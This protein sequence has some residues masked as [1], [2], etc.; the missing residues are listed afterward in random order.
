MGATSVLAA[1]E[2]SNEQLKKAVQLFDQGQYEQSQELLLGLDQGKL[3]DDEKKQRDEYADKVTVAIN[4][5][6]KAQQD[7]DDG[8]SLYDGNKLN[9]AAKKYRAVQTNK[10]AAPAQ[11]QEAERRLALIQEKRRLSESTETAQPAQPGSAAPATQPT[12]TAPEPRAA[13]KA[14]P[15]TTRP[16]MMQM[17]SRD[18][19][20]AAALIQRGQENLRRGEFDAAAKAFTEALRL[21]PNDPD[22]LA[23]RQLLEKYRGAEGQP[24]S[25][26]NRYQAVRSLR[27]QRTQRLYREQEEKARELML[28]HKYDEA[29]QLLQIAGRTLEAGKMDAQPAEE[30]ETMHREL[31][32]LEEYLAKEQTRYQEEQ[33]AD[34]VRTARQENIERE[35]RDREE[36]DRKIQQMMERVVQLKKDRKY[37]EAIAQL[38][39]ILVVEPN[40]QRARDMKDDLE[41]L[42]AQLQAGRG[43]DKLITGTRDILQQASLSRTPATEVMTYSDR[44]PEIKAMRERAAPGLFETAESDRLT[45]DIDQRLKGT[46]I[47]PVEFDARPLKE[48]LDHFKTEGKI[49]IAPNW[50]A[51]EIANVTP[52]TEVTATLGKVKLD[53]A[54]KTI[55][56]NISDPAVS[57]IEFEVFGG[58]VRVSTQEDLDQ[59]ATVTRVYDIADVVMQDNKKPRRR[60]EMGGLMGNMGGQG[61]G[62]S[63]GM[64][65]GMGGGMSGGGMSG[66]GMNSGGSSGGGSDDDDDTDTTEKKKEITDSLI[67][68]MKEQIA[69]GTWETTGV[70]VTSF[71]NKKLLIRHR[72]SIQ[73]QVVQLLKGLSKARRDQVAVEARLL[74]IRKNFLEEIGLDL[75][76]V[77]NQGTAGFDRSG[78]TDATTGAPLLLPRQFGRVG[79]TPNVPAVGSPLPQSALQQPY[80]NVAMVPQA[81]GYGPTWGKSTPIPILNNSLS[82]AQPQSTPVPGSLGGQ[83]QPAL[84]VFGSFLDNIQVDFL[85]RATQADVHSSIVDAPRLVVASGDQSWVSVFESINYVF[86]VYPVGA[87]VFTTGVASQAALAPQVTQ[88]YT[89]RRLIVTATVSESRDYVTLQVSPEWSE[90]VSIDRFPWGPNGEGFI[91]QPRT[92][93]TEFSTTVTV[94]DE[95]TLLLGGLTLSGETEVEAGVPVLSK[96]PVLKRLYS[97]RSL[98]KDEYVAF[99]LIKPHIIV[100]SEQEERAFPGMTSS[101]EAGR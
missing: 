37:P 19:E 8:N 79:F 99:V 46:T 84:Q 68:L 23:G 70:S 90:L 80:S 24:S 77:L 54:L 22:A 69:P 32:Q 14:A 72:P 59:T 85:L 10:Y 75:D 82:L 25:L 28:S 4:Q 30:Y 15:A 1:A 60:G 61:G 96:V 47:E 16:A 98:V 26:L 97:N 86:A 11:K 101:S 64:S 74:T 17:A 55:L 18:Q 38:K 95:G 81:G 35:R 52:D 51:L 33:V 2:A 20:Q 56:E 83:N 7:L 41:D 36:R 91:Q 45:A 67:S 92:R 58:Q 89:G 43:E 5:S 57:P 65:G 76:V 49:Q 42:Y 3:S 9:E 62:M 88:L 73:K 53:M 34:Q 13:A 21:A 50:K 31:G 71:Q 48:V 40:Y 27:W 63:G 100:Q 6:K 93:N 39:E 66:G 12:K 44:W 94:P 78:L 29:K 87:N